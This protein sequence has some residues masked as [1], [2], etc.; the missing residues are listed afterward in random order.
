M[1]HTLRR[2]L[3]LA[4]SLSLAAL[5]LPQARAQF[6]APTKEELT[7]TSQPEVPG[8]AAVYL[9]REEITDDKTHTWTIYARMKILTERGKDQATVEVRQYH[10]TDTVLGYTVVDIQGRTIHPDGTI[11]PFTGK[12]F[13]KLIERTEGFK[14]NAKVFTLP[15]VEVGSII[16]YRFT[17]QYDDRVTYI[18][19]WLIQSPF[20]TRR[21][22]YIWNA[23]LSGNA[24]VAGYSAAIAWTVVLPKG[25]DVVQTRTPGTAVDSGASKLE[26][27][28]HDVPPIPDEE[29]MPPIASLSYRVLFNFSTYKTPD[30]FWKAEGKL[31]SAAHDKF[32]GPGPKVKAAVQQ[33]VAPS[34]TQDQKLRKLYAAV[35]QLDNASFDRQHSAQ[36]DKSQGL[37][38]AKSADDILERKRGNATQL[39][40]LFVAMARAAG[41][42]AYLMGVTAR[43]RNRFVP[44]YL[45]FRQLNDYVAIVT[46]DGKEQFFDP[47]QRYCPYQHLAWKD[48]FAQ[49]VRQTDGGTA[50]DGTPGEPYAASRTQR[51]ANLTMDDQGNVTGTVKMAWTG[52][53]ALTWRQTSLRV[54]NTGLVNDLQGAVER[55]VPKEMDVKLSGIQNLDDYEQPLI[56]TFDVKGHIASATGKRLLVPGDIFEARSVARFPHEKRDYPVYFQFPYMTQDAVRIAIPSSLSVESLPPAQKLP[57]E[58]FAAYS[59]TTES[60]PASITVRRDLLLSNII[61]TPAEYSNLR[62]FYS[63]FQA[64]DQE[65]AVLKVVAAPSSGN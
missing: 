5:A 48:T 50:I 39:T 15:D 59:L 13:E 10:I 65:P 11:I 23:K 32:I 16:E 57:F 41:M 46:V 9:D 61:Y 37:N 3:R 6:I 18:P 8:A 26:L 34:D 1:P 49:G 54:D 62:T 14:E 38:P 35:M 44:A 30:E 63:Q 17:L 56:V 64:K 4:L 22:H 42:K 2:P 31:W 36:E 60:T 43:D 52:A 28:I 21:A 7:M 20:F 55:L 33:L 24:S 47:G 58:K 53:P 12:P 19:E 51:V 45:N 29:F 40:E 27:N 25:V